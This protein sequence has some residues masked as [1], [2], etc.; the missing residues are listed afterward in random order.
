MNNEKVWELISVSLEFS[1]LEYSFEDNLLKCP[2][3]DSLGI[4]TLI[5]NFKE[6]FNVTLEVKKLNSLLQFRDLV[7]YILSKAN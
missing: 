6:K 5:G 7:N 1:P 3:W 2:T 4:L